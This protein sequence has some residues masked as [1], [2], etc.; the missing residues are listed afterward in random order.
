MEGIERLNT[1]QE[2]SKLYWDLWDAQ[3]KAVTEK[4]Y[5]ILKDLSLG[6]APLLPLRE[7]EM[8]SIEGKD[9][10]DETC[11]WKVRKEIY[12]VNQDP[13]RNRDYDFGSSFTL[14]IT[15]KAIRINHGSCGE[16]GLDD[17]GQWSRLILMKGIFD[18]Q[19]DIIDSLSPLIDYS[20]REILYDVNNEID[21]INRAIEQAQR[22]KE[23]KEIFATVKVGKY[24]CNKKPY[25]KWE[26]DENGNETSVKVYQYVGHEKITKISEKTIT[27]T[28]PWGY[29]RRYKITQIIYQLRCKSLYIVDNREVTPPEEEGSK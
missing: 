26:T 4:L 14:V 7:N 3:K 16:W 5:S 1:L 9:W 8:V 18:H 10:L 23:D 20:V 25:W 13:T 15:N 6:P 11:L 19:Q 21:N 2:K 12:F 27:T 28:D 17:K 22:E 29:N 24:I